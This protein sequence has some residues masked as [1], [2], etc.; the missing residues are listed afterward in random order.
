MVRFPQD[1]RAA[2]DSMSKQKTFITHAPN[3]LQVSIYYSSG[4]RAYKR[5]RSLY[6]ACDK[7]EEAAALVTLQ[8]DHAVE[9]APYKTAA[10]FNEA[11]A[12]GRLPD[13]EIV[14]QL[15]EDTIEQGS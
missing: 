10:C 12:S 7:G 13:C 15:G 1:Y 4:G 14:G 6:S 5:D 2:D 3:C 9:M 8:D 11:V